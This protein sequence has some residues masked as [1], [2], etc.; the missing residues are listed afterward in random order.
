MNRQMCGIGGI[1]LLDKRKHL[2]KDLQVNALTML[3]ELQSRGQHAWGVYLEKKGKQGNLYCGKDCSNI[4]GEIFK[5]PKSVSDF[6]EEC[7]GKIYLDDA[8]VVL[9]HTRASTT[10]DPEVNEN[11][12]PFN[13]NDFI[14][15]HN[16]VIRN[17]TE[18]LKKFNIK[19]KIE[20]DSYAI[21]ALIQHFYKTNKSVKE[22]IIEMSKYIQ[23]SYA[24]WLYHKEKKE[25]YLFRNTGT[26]PI[27]FFFDKENNLLAFAS[28]DAQIVNA[29]ND[30]EINK[31]DCKP[32][33]QDKIFKLTGN[34]LEEVGE[35][36]EAESTQTTSS[37]YDNRR[38]PNNYQD[39]F[40]NDYKSNRMIDTTNINDSLKELYK[41]FE[42][43][44]NNSADIKTGIYLCEDT[45]ILLVNPKGLIKMLDEAG[46]GKFKSKTKAKDVDFW[47]YEIAPMNKINDLVASLTNETYGGTKGIIDNDKPFKENLV[48]LAE[49]INCTLSEG[50][51]KFIFT[52]T[53]KSQVPP[54]VVKV[55]KQQGLH[56]RRNKVMRIPIND[57]NEEKLLH[58]LKAM[59][60]YRG[61]TK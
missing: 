38:Y 34:E 11:N 52:Y 47:K 12:H 19:T 25:L 18:M 32:L 39:R 16:G 4:P 36:K 27:E 50:L 55:F 13:T 5:Q 44:D 41:I 1:V 10:G 29:Y 2:S 53:G 6:F 37:I 61:A 26:S 57:K 3:M 8:N 46:F 45:V 21:I 51:N 35:L 56:F 58:I 20:C 28:E 42:W 48:D 7:S 14:L 31:S 15:A 23:G 24:C 33:P 22:S 43:F 59:K 30:P 60:I 40:S 9:M 54:W 49:T 17:H